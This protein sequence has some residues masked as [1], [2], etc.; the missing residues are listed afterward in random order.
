MV[1]LKILRQGRV[2]GVW[3]YCFFFLF[4]IGLK[5]NSLAE[6]FGFSPEN[7]SSE[8][9]FSQSNG[10]DSQAVEISEQRDVE[11]PLEASFYDDLEISK[12]V[13]SEQ[14]L[15]S[16]L[17]HDSEML[18]G[19]LPNGFRYVLYR[20]PYPKDRVYAVLRV[21]AGSLMETP[22]AGGIAHF[23]EHVA[24]CGSEHFPKGEM[25]Q[26]LQ[27]LGV[28]FGP[29]VNALT[30]LDH[31]DYILNLPNT[32]DDLF[33]T[34]LDIFHDYACA[35]KIFPEEVERERG[36][37]LSEVRDRDGPMLRIAR[38]AVKH[39]FTGTL[40]ADAISVGDPEVIG[41]ATAAQLRDFYEKWYTPDRM[42]LVI[43]GDFSPEKWQ[44]IVEAKMSSIPAKEKVSNPYEGECPS[45]E[46][47]VFR[48]L[49]DEQSDKV[50]VSI[51]SVSPALPKEDSIARRRKELCRWIG[52]EILDERLQDRNRAEA[53]LFLSSL[54]DQCE[55]FPRWYY[56]NVY[57]GD[58]RDWRQALGCIEQELR[59]IQEFGF[60]PQEVDRMRKKLLSAVEHAYLAFETLPSSGIASVMVESL[61]RDLYLLSPQDGYELSRRLLA[62]LEPDDVTR[63][64]N[65][66]W[67][68]PNRS[69]FMSGPEDLGESIHS[70]IEKAYEDSMQIPVTPPQAKA[71]EEFAYAKPSSEEPFSASCVE[72]R[73]YVEDLDFHQIIFKNHVRLNIKT[74]D[75]EKDRIKVAIHFGS[76]SLEAEPGEEGLWELL[77]SMF[78]E[79]GLGRHSWEDL[80]KILAVRVLRIHFHTG[81]DSFALRG[82]STTRDFR[83]LCELAAAYFEDP[84]Y[85]E[86]A[87]SDALKY[88]RQLE[89]GKLKS[90]GAVYALEI[91]YRLSGRHFAFRQPEYNEIER[92]TAQDVARRF[93]DILQNAYVEISVVGDCSVE[94]VIRHVGETFGPMPPREDFPKSFEKKR[95]L[96]IPEAKRKNFHYHSDGSEHPTAELHLFWPGLAEDNIE[97]YRRQLLLANILSERLLERVRH[98]MGEAYSPY[99]HYLQSDV[100]PSYQWMHVE[101]SVDPTKIVSVETV[102]LK[103]VERLLKDGITED[104]FQRMIEPERNNVRDLRRRNAYWLNVLSHSQRDGRLLSY[105]RTMEEFYQNVTRKDLEAVAKILKKESLR[106]YHILPDSLQKKRHMSQNTFWRRKHR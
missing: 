15:E 73:H 67:S 71:S 62:S 58:L 18:M 97:L 11:Q 44:S 10:P 101:I 85:R 33:S 100:F 34:A 46:K 42:I 94:E 81:E 95:I 4:V 7:F 91:P 51:A 83:L 92:W 2:I 17:R 20:H 61:H 79:G 50:A 36:V 23:L 59:K 104:E 66:M 56:G 75:F 29:D 35:L 74:S 103:E 25:I 9:S 19:C 38:Q 52:R 1:N 6:D 48:Y 70:E 98:D 45:L 55:V 63:E 102:F 41:K 90:P 31:T 106:C 68:Y 69:V 88:F 96:Q 93:Q 84:A 37:I 105:A 86:D 47:K 21:R 65:E 8:E 27:K 26:Y 28:A 22:V 64:W 54:V 76:G 60:W 16:Y 13:D 24:F 80:E 72:S 3:G 78:L 99:A 12:S 57:L 49:R 39:M 87:R 32:G 77:G 82:W 89:E 5:G 43:V 40:F 14:P 53:N 30:G